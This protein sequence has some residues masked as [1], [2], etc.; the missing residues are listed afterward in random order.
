MRQPIVL[1][2]DT[3]IIS[4]AFPAVFAWLGLCVVYL[5]FLSVGF[6]F[7]F[8]PPILPVII[9][10]LG[11]SHTEAGLLMSLFA[12]PGILLSLPGG[13]LVDRYGERLIGGL[14]VILM[15]AGTL[16]LGWA[17]SFP[18]ILLARVLSGIGAMVGVVAL[19]RLVVRLFAGR[20]LGLP[21]GISGSAVPVGIIIVLNLAGPLAENEGWRL[22]AERVGG[23]T[24]L[25]G[26]V[27]VVAI[28]FITRGQELGRDPAAAPSEIKT[29]HPDQT[30]MFR[31]L[32]IG[33]AVWFCANGAMTAFMT[34]A[35]DH[36]QGLGFDVS[37]R[38]L[39]TSIPMWTSAAL[40]MLTGW[41]TDRHGGRPTFMAAGL[42][43]MGLAL[44]V[45]PTATVPPA[46][47]GLLLGLSL[48]AVVTPTI[49]LPGVLLPSSHTGRG[50]GILST[51]ANVGIFVVP[52]LAGWL[53][54]LTGSYM[55]PFLLMGGVA[56][57]GVVAAE[58]LRRGKFM[59]GFSRQALALAAL[60][61]VAGCGKQ[62]RYEVVTPT[63]GVAGTLRMGQLTEMKVLLSANGL[64]GTDAWGAHD[65]LQV[66]HG[67]RVVRV[68]DDLYTTLRFP[69][70]P[71]LR[72]VLCEP[73]GDAL[74]VTG[75]GEFWRWSGGQ[76]Q[77]LAALPGNDTTFLARD[78][79]GRP[80][81]GAQ[82]DGEALYRYEAGAWTE[83]G[84]GTWGKYRTVWS[85][86]DGGTF[87]ATDLNQVLEL[88]PTGIA[89][90]DSVEFRDTYGIGRL[91][92]DST[93]R[94]AYTRGNREMWVRDGGAGQVF[95]WEMFFHPE[96]LFWRA[97]QL[98]CVEDGGHLLLWDGVSWVEQAV[99][100]LGRD[101]R[102]SIDLA[103]QQLVVGQYGEAFL[104][105]GVTSTQVS[106]NQGNYDGL[107]EFQDKLLIYTERGTLFEA[108]STT[109]DGWRFVAQT[110]NRA[111]G[112]NSNNALLVDDLG[113]LIIKDFEFL[114][115]WDGAALTRIPLDEPVMR[116]FRMPSGEIL[117]STLDGVA[118]LVQSEIDF[119]P[120]PGFSGYSCRGLRRRSPT[121]IEILYD[122]GLYVI[123]PGAEP[124]LDWSGVGWRPE[125]MVSLA[126]DWAMV[127]GYR[128]THELIG[129][130]VHDAGLYVRLDNAAVAPTTTDFCE[131]EGG[132]LVGWSTTLDNFVLRESDGVWWQV[133]LVH[134]PG[135]SVMRNI[136]GAQFV[137]TENHG[138]LI[139]GNY[140]I[141][142]LD[143][144]GDTP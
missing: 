40:G 84:D 51:C 129:G 100:F 17:P 30:R 103:G 18:L 62:D 42:F 1:K 8:L 38:G 65:V 135:S 9:A 137:R 114:W 91:A 23:M 26:V 74:V 68:Q 21:L 53:H 69:G 82:D 75:N 141:G 33:G 25:I 76:W 66:G 67:G 46:F 94:L 90:V 56:F 97:G 81:A 122:Y 70:D 143:L 28:S 79:Q 107:A 138:L 89:V 106:R 34:F 15:G 93:G 144:M 127:M 72:G 43:L 102:L 50:Y 48:A 19:Q 96:I 3:G 110:E 85:S 22:V 101:A 61:L 57:S 11:L 29:A 16:L 36:F 121:E 111:R 49:A 13:W 31:P 123:S 24:A 98:Y 80:L 115:E 73:N 108:A 41:L 112:D 14:G 128:E 35:P 99:H 142:V 47:I 117:I 140:F 71:Y 105:D 60:L 136:G 7:H 95:T 77:E 5:G 37:A 109:A 78:D 27:F 132:R 104:Y 86:P 130:Q 32:W 64:K 134:S 113:R 116:M 126:E 133:G 12:L 4:A 52:P 20:S 124:R 63:V 119:Q 88:T 120:T 58:I 6:V 44:I 45:L 2:T 87:L 125:R 83:V 92:G 39:F 54:D 139:L 118:S 59:P 55:W 131:L 10:D